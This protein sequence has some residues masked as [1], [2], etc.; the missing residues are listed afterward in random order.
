MVVFG[1][2]LVVDSGCWLLVP[3]GAGDPEDLGRNLNF[4]VRFFEFLR[5]RFF[6][7]TF[8]LGLSNS[9]CSGSSF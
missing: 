8:A 6:R 2:W 5:A 1:F 7:L 9:G 4:R 3:L